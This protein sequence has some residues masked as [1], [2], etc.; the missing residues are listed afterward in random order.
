VIADSDL[1]GQLVGFEIMDAG[2]FTD[3]SKVMIYMSKWD[4]DDRVVDAHGNLSISPR[5]KKAISAGD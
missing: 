4:D 5:H 2:E 3:L 1:D